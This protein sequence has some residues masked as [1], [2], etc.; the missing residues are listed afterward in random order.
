M[1]KPSRSETVLFYFSLLR[2]LFTGNS[3]NSL[4]FMFGCLQICP[5]TV[6]VI[7]GLDVSLKVDSSSNDMQMLR[8]FLSLC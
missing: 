7:L 6:S 5:V 1:L 2:R 4:R 8:Y 3:L